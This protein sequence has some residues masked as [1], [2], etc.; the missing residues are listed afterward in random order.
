MYDGAKVFLDHPENPNE[1]RS[2]KDLVGVLSGPKPDDNGL[3]AD[4]T[5]NPEHPLRQRHRLARQE[6]PFGDRA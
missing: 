4:L 1:G 2:V 6:P 3:S 5:L